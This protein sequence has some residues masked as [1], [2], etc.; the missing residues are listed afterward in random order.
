[1]IYSYFD[2]GLKTAVC[3][4]LTNAK[5]PPPIALES[6]S[7]AQTGRPVFQHA[8]KKTSLWG[9][10]FFY[11]W[12]H[13]WS[14]FRV[15]LAHVVWPK[16]QPLGQSVSLKFL[17]ETTLESKSFEPLI[18]FLAQGFLTGGKFHPSSGKLFLIWCSEK[19]F[20]SNT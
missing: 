20:Y 18:N 7:R 5:A 11:E 16:A 6:C 4:C 8:L 14:S 17:L 10:R 19:L 12:R 3:G 9:L 15:I 2:F 13:K 1:M